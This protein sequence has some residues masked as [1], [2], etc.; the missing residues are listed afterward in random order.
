MA[1]LIR[2]SLQFIA[3]AL[4]AFPASGSSTPSIEKTAT[5]NSHQKEQEDVIV[6]YENF[7]NGLPTGWSQQYL[8]GVDGF[9]ASWNTRTGAG[10]ISP[11]NTIGVPDT[12]AVGNK[13]LVFQMQNIGYVTRLITP[14]I[15]LEFIVN[16]ELSF[17]HAQA[18]WDEGFL[19]MLTIYYRL[20]DEGPWHLL[21]SYQHPVEIWTHR[22][23]PLN[24]HESDRFYL[25]FEGVSGWGSGICIDELKIT[26]T[27]FVAKELD[28]FTTEQASLNFM[29]TGST[30]NPILM[31]TLRVTGNTG[32]ITLDS[33]Q[34]HS[35]NTDDNDI[36]AVKLYY[37]H[38]EHFNNA[39]LVAEADGFINGVISFENIELDLPTGYSYIWLTYDISEDASHGNYADAYI[40]AHGIVIDGETLPTENH[41]PPGRR[42]IFE[43]IFYDDFET[44]KGWIFSGEWER[45]E[46]QG[47]GGSHGHP[48]A[49][50]AHTGN[51]IIGTDLSGQGA[52]PGDMEPGI[53]YMEYVAISPLFDCFYYKDV[54]LSFHRWLNSE[55]TDKVWIH[56][57][58]DG[59]ATWHKVWENTN[60]NNATGWSSQPYNLSHINRMDQ[61]RIRFGAGPT[62]DTNNYSGWNIDNLVVTGTFITHDVGV[63]E[64]VGPEQGCGMST[65]ETVVVKVENFGAWAVT[66]PVP[67][68]F[69]L[70]GGQTWHMDTLYQNIPVGST[71]QHT[72]APKADFSVP[73]RYDNIIVKT[74]WEE[75]QDNNNDALHHAVFSIPYITPPYSELFLTSDGLWTGYGENSTWEWA[76]PQ[77]S[78]ISTA[79]SGTKAWITNASGTY[80]PSEASWL[81]S[82]C[83]NL[84]EAENPVIEFY[85]NIHSLENTD[86][87]GIQYSLDQGV[88]WQNLSVADP[89]LAWGW[90]E[91]E[92]EVSALKNIF[93]HTYGWHGDT[94]G[95]Q[96]VRAV[97]GPEV[98]AESHV[99]FRLVF[100]AQDFDPASYQWE[101]AGFDAFAI[102]EA[103][104]DVGV[105]ALEEPTDNCELSQEQEVTVTIKNYGINSIPAGMQIPTGIEIGE[106]PGA[107][108]FFTLSADLAPGATTNFTF[109]T[110]FDMSEQGIHPIVAFTMLPGDND[111]YQPGVFNDTLITQVT[112]FG[113]PQFSLGQDIYTT[114]PDTVVIDAGIGFEQYLWQDGST[115]QTFEVVSANSAFYTATVTDSNG[116]SVS[117]SLEVIARDISV[118]AITQPVSDCELSAQ[119][120]VMTKI[121]NTGPDPY[122][123]G[124]EIPF[125][126]FLNGS[127]HDETSLF[128]QNDLLPGGE[129]LITFQN[130]ADLS[131]TGEHQFVVI[132]DLQDANPDNNELEQSI[133]VHGFP[134]PFI[135]DTLYTQDHESVTLDAGPGYVSYLWQDGHDGQTYP[136]TNP[137]SAWYTV[138]VTDEWGCPGTD[139]VLVVTYDIEIAEVIEPSESCEL[140][141]EE[142]IG[143]RL[144]N[145]GPETFQPGHAFAFILELQGEFISED[146]LLLQQSWVAGEEME[147]YFSTTVNMLNAQT[148]NFLAYQKHRD[149]N[150]DNDELEFSITVHGYPDIYL[151]P[152]ISTDQPENILLIPNPDETFHAYLWQDGSTEEQYDVQTWGQY[153]VEVSNEFGCIS[154]ATT[155]VYPEMMDL[156]LDSIISPTA[157][158]A[159]DQE[160]MVTVAIRNTGYMDIE[161]GTQLVLSYHLDGLL[162]AE[163]TITTVNTIVPDGVKHYTFQQTFAVE[164]GHTPAITATIDFWADEIEENNSLTGTFQLIPLPQPWLGDNIYTLNPAGIALSPGEGFESY[165]WQ[166]GSEE[167]TFVISSVH[168]ETYSVTVS[169]TTGCFNTASVDVVTF[170]LAMDSIVSPQS[171]CVLTEAEEVIVKVYNEGYDS[172]QQ[173]H[174]ITLGFQLE[175]HTGVVQEDFTLNAPWPA[176]SYQYFSFTQPVNLSSSSS[177]NLW[178]FVITPNAVPETDTLVSMIE[179]TAVPEVNLGAHIYTSRPDTVVL[180]AGAGFSSYYWHD[181]Y[182]EQ[183]YNVSGYGWK[184]VFV[185]DPYGCTGTD[186]TYVG[187]FTDVIQLDAGFSSNVYPNPARSS[188]T[189]EMENIPSTGVTMEFSDING[190]VRIREQLES[191]AYLRQTVNIEDLAPGVYFIH[192]Y[193]D[194]LRKSHKITILP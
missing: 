66:D 175:G 46:P 170:N 151:P 107:Y 37:T 58:G 7:E 182:E 101:G 60:F 187:Y 167:T 89:S 141:E 13:N 191:H 189:I 51:K 110:L 16:P 100:A 56:V 185:T 14:P 94:P 173:G 134:E 111:F 109:E 31:S 154:T 123:A 85:L 67:L 129:E 75:D 12:A 19:D 39:N 159:N 162:I 161:P 57:S 137:W 48:G 8:A 139:S 40:P 87:I 27:G 2:I 148:Y 194:H 22:T 165:L 147:L 128:L 4:F 24:N 132:S 149:V 44:D 91:D 81:E 36:S 47:L 118:I 156:A 150:T 155:Q 9:Y 64:W 23:L 108:E 18:E 63:T 138:T 50:H 104:H 38:Q 130:P 143:I 53:G 71:V 30:N 61:V 135:G 116:C 171:H 55:T 65:E 166:D 5:E 133:F 183:V 73:G 29:P 15:D 153:W 78:E 70:D 177:Y 117:D 121:S 105:F 32:N 125:R 114:M 188:I 174:S 124:T 186:T 190:R 97:L 140:S 28:N 172:F 103:P 21:E 92:N 79:Q 131:Q 20:G 74:F 112:V 54:T 26:E 11:P 178:G 72:F 146:T 113:Y 17:Y 122:S 168:S 193:S 43:T 179:K 80:N 88:I 157:V 77:G 144:V 176:N 184:W 82:P 127:L 115:G 160:V 119:E 163:E 192:L 90:Y 158:C 34:A 62:D 6:L 59:G 25:A 120:Y 69:S 93:G 68:G 106:L 95:W 35:L 52:Y 164:N 181:G 96:R 136:L 76:T 33:Y 86:G 98:T 84:A 83:F 99:K 180:D 126:L 41:S 45:G 152:Y 49:T 3:V 102:F 142:T 1:T 42:I 10:I 145:H 169:D